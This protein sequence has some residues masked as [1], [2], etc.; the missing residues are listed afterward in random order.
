[1]Q[2]LDD[3]EPPRDLERAWA[4]WSLLESTGWRFLMAPGGLLDQPEALMGDV[5]VIAWL[6]SIVERHVAQQAEAD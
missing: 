5:A 4:V 1:L 6:S 2:D 3:W